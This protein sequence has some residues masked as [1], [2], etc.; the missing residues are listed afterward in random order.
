MAIYNKNNNNKTINEAPV[1]I[2][3]NSGGNNS[4]SIS[5]NKGQTKGSLSRS[6]R[7][8]NVE[9]DAVLEESAGENNQYII[10]RVE[11]NTHSVNLDKFD[12][13]K[14]VSF[15]TSAGVNLNKEIIWEKA[16]GE[17]HHYQGIYKIPKQV[18]G[19]PI[20]QANT[21]YIELDIKNLDNVLSRSFRWN[22]N[23]LDS[24]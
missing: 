14:N 10:I 7:E 2:G 19:K 6:N 20:I 5:T 3:A 8:G 9:V 11:F 17:G 1:N 13:S 15:K 18:N 16:R 23:V 4:G 12:F 22:K 24:I 21:E